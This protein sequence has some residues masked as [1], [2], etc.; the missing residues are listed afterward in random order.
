MSKSFGA[1]WR[2]RFATDA[3]AGEA[4]VPD[5][6]LARLLAHR[7]H[8][9]YTDQRIDEAT[10]STLLAT[11]LSA[12]SKSDLQQVS[13]I[14]IQDHDTR[15]GI[16]AL[17]P[18]M[19]WIGSAPEFFIFC[20][21]NRRIR[22]ICRLRGLDYANNTMDAVFNATIDAAIAMQT[23]IAAAEII[24]LGSCP[25]SHVRDHIDMVAQMLSIPDGV[26]PIS[27][28]C[29]G[30]PSQ[31][32]FISLRLSPAATVHTDR[33]DDSDL[34]A[35]LDA[36]D[37]RRDAVYSIP[38]DKYKHTD[39]FGTPV[40]YGWS[41]DKARQMALNDGQTMRSYLTDKGFDLS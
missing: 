6:A 17:I 41:E 11:C 3:P 20:G 8:R 7:T 33:Y 12:P 25:I 36:Y 37:R 26:F 40:F 15:A 18:S 27:G 19:P 39:R 30:H 4:T 16:A 38:A 2:D 31:D 10:V 34:T 14:R 21:D 13:I 22:E 1:L 29:L 32:G 28:L 9:G 5:A 35:Q 23:M 24:G